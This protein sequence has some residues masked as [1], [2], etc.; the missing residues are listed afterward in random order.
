M[1]YVLYVEFV[2][3]HEALKN[4]IT[5]QGESRISVEASSDSEAVLLATQMVNATGRIATGHTMLS[6][7]FCGSPVWAGTKWCARHEDKVAMARLG[8]A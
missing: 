7:C 5:A 4:G 8:N 2:R 1:V 6:H 3:D